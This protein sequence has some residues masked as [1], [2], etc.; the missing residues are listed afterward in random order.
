[1]LCAGLGGM[2][3]DGVGFGCFPHAQAFLPPFVDNLAESFYGTASW[4]DYWS[5]LN[6]D[7]NMTWGRAFMRISSQYCCV[8]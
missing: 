7:G 4:D 3:K 5:K 6:T 2:G 8:D 1:M